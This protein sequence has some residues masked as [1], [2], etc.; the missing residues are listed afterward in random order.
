MLIALRHTLLTALLAF[1]ILAQTTATLAGTVIDPAGNPVSDAEVF[2]ENELTG[3]RTEERSDAE[4]H[5]TLTNIPFH[6]YN[7]TVSK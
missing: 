5:F 6:A 1:P 7:V 3:Y 2:L 4:G